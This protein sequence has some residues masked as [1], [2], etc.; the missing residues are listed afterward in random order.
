MAD[1]RIGLRPSSGCERFWK[2]SVMLSAHTC[3]ST[4]AFRPYGQPVGS[5]KI[6]F[7]FSSHS[8]RWDTSERGSHLHFAALPPP[9]QNG[10]MLRDAARVV[11]PRPMAVMGSCLAVMGALLNPRAVLPAVLVALVA[12]ASGQNF[13]RRRLRVL[14]RQQS[15]ALPQTPSYLSRQLAVAMERSGAVVSQCV[16]ERCGTGQLVAVSRKTQAAQLQADYQMLHSAVCT[17]LGALGSHPGPSASP[18][19]L[20]RMLGELGSEHA[21][22]TLRLEAAASAAEAR[23]ARQAERAM[24]VELAAKRDRAE[25]LRMMHEEAYAELAQGRQEAER[26]LDMYDE[27]VERLEE[28]VETLENERLE[29]GTY[30]QETGQLDGEAEGDT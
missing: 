17:A 11:S 30:L 7:V 14:Q 2:Q 10:L 8:G 5:R 6:I 3:T 12:Y 26:Q 9:R 1:R 28:R 13:E 15:A 24:Q 29:L 27:M 21:I 22:R 20:A 16:K 23:R 18:L 25:R 19:E 4:A